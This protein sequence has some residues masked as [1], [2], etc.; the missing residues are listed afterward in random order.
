ML[1]LHNYLHS[2]KNTARDSSL[3]VLIYS[4]YS[5]D[6]EDCQEVLSYL[7]DMIHEDLNRCK[8]S[9]QIVNKDYYGDPKEEWAAESWQE[10]LK[11]NKSIIVDLF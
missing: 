6:Q 11:A 8:Q 7:L 1:I 5:V 2:Y 3:D 10:H 9:I 4:L